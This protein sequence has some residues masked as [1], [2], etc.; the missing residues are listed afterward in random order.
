MAVDPLMQLMQSS[1][2]CPDAASDLHYVALAGTC[3]PDNV[4]VVLMQQ[5]T[6]ITGVPAHTP[7]QVI[8]GS[9]TPWLR[10]TV[11][12]HHLP[13]QHS[14]SALARTQVQLA[15]AGHQLRAAGCSTHASWQGSAMPLLATHGICRPHVSTEAQTVLPT[16]PPNQGDWERK[17]LETHQPPVPGFSQQKKIH[18]V[19]AHT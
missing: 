18:V 2:A 17:T 14:G 8:A 11:R 6:G 19:H 5:L 10:C 15:V 12:H 7:S 16:A 1:A 3:H 9:S 4:L 13:S